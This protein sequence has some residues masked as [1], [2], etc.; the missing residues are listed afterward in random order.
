MKLSFLKSR[1]TSDS[2][3]TCGAYGRRSM[4]H[5]WINPLSTS[6]SKRYFAAGSVRDSNFDKS[7]S[8]VL[9]FL[10]SSLSMIRSF[11]SKET[12]CEDCLLDSGLA[13]LVT[14][15]SNHPFQSNFQVP[16]FGL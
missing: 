9:A 6:P 7:A 11:L 5:S 15:E 13:R 16:F 8:V 10:T 12:G 1:R 2:S 3:E 4:T 14:K